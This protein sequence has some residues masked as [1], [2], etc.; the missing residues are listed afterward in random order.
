MA[1]FAVAVF[2]ASESSVM[3]ALSS[4]HIG[5]PKVIVGIVISSLLVDNVSSDVDI[6][7]A[8]GSTIV[9]VAS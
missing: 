2:V 1:V 8:S 5:D 7:F 4:H 6:L 9:S 3:A